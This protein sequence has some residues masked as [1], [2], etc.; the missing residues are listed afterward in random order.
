MSDAPQDR[1]AER[2]L[3]SRTA[4]TRRFAPADLVALVLSVLWLLLTGVAFLFLGRGTEDGVDPLRF[5]MTLVAVFVPVALIWLGNATVKSAAAMRAESQRLR[6]TVE[7]LRSSMAQQR[8]GGAS[9]EVERRLQEIAA[10]T[11]KTETALATFTSIRTA[12]PPPPP[13]SEP[14]PPG[15]AP[16]EG[17]GQPTLGLETPADAMQAQLTTGDFIAALQFPETAEDREGFRALRRALRDRNTA[18]LIQAAQDVLTLLSQ[19]GV[20]MDD[21]APDRA[22]PELWRRFAQGERGRAIAALGGI[23]DKDA[24]GLAAARMKNDAIFR[25]A[26]HHFLRRFD[27]IFAAFEQGA[28]DQEIAALADTRTARAFM[29]LGRVTGTFD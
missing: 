24:L 9:P 27:Q 28:S 11:K 21:L 3:L 8:A 17:E 7:G 23:H 5:V 29:L 20:Y 22:R 4:E 14:P 16:A 19:D 1:P 6:A 25:D 12:A 18:H 26:A 2:G 13:R 15:P 10:T